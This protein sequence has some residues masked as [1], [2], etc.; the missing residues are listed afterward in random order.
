MPAS[1]TWWLASAIM[2]VSAFFASE[3]PQYPTRLTEQQRM[4]VESRRHQEDL[5]G[6]LDFEQLARITNE[7]KIMEMACW[8]ARRCGASAEC[9]EKAETTFRSLY[10][11]GASKLE[12]VCMA[13]DERRYVHLFYLS[14]TCKRSTALRKFIKHLREHVLRGGHTDISW[15]PSIVRGRGAAM[16]N[17]STWLVD[18]YCAVFHPRIY[19]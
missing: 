5:H 13:A 17:E 11:G 16:Y 15:K 1:T 6:L 4:C 2:Y 18:I 19:Q 7:T 12:E 14:R 3:P 8:E 10:L 9:C